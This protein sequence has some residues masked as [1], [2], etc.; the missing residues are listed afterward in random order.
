MSFS[1]SFVNYA[2]SDHMYSHV[3]CQT[4][5]QSHQLTVSTYLWSGISVGDSPCS[6]A[7][8]H[9]QTIGFTAQI[10]GIFNV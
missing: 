9:T 5:V 10:C 3:V 1:D 8:V 7:Q 2:T 4:Q 6:T